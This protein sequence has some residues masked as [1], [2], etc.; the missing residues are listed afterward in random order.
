ML[1]DLG[2]QRGPRVAATL[3]SIN[4]EARGSQK[5]GQWSARSA[6]PDAAR[7]DH[8]VLWYGTEHCHGNIRYVSPALRHAGAHVAIPATRHALLIKARNLHSS[9]RFGATRRPVTLNPARE[10]VV[11]ACV[12]AASKQL[13][14]A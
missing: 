4:P 7:A 2:P 13:R 11:T 3:T 9:R 1:A 14:A 6:D 8:S 5:G 12:E 10:P